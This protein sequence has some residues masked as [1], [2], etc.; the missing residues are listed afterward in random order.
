MKTFAEKEREKIKMFIANNDIETAVGLM[1]FQIG[2]KSKLQGTKYLH[3]AL[4]EMQSKEHCLCYELYDKIAQKF[5]TTAVCVERSIRHSINSCLLDGALSRANELL[6][7][8]I[9]DEKYPPTNRELIF[10]LSAWI[11]L[12]RAM[13]DNMPH[14]DN[15]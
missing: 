5:Q 11:R 9:V 14:P 6:D 7:M 10:Q 3:A 8:P 4:V 13:C 2:F 15:N 12:V 1:L